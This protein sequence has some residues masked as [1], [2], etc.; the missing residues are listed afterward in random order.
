MRTIL[1]SEMSECGLACLAMVADHYGDEHDL[2]S[3]R[4]RFSTSLKGMTLTH[5]IRRASDLDLAAR[6]LKVEV[7]ELH[8]L[9]LP[10]ILHWN[11]NHFVVLKKVK[12][13]T[14]GQT[15]YVINDPAIGLLK[16]TATDLSRKFTG[17]GIEFTPT[18]KFTPKKA[19]PTISVADLAGKISGLPS[20]VAQAII[21][22][23]ALELFALVTPLFNQFVIDE[24]L[25]SGDVDMLRVSVAGFGLLVLVQIVIG[26]ARSLFLIR[27]GGEIGYQWAARLFAHLI[28][29]PASFFEKRNLG[30]VVSRFGSISSIQNTMTSLLV[31]SLLDGIMAFAALGMMFF[32]S[33]KMSLIVLSGVFVYAVSRILLF[34]LIKNATFERI[35]SAAKENTH[36]LETIRSITP[37]KLFGREETRA[38][39]WS[40]LKMNTTNRDISLQKINVFFKSFTGAI[41][42]VQLLALLYC[43]ASLVMAKEMSVGMMIAFGSYGSTFAM[44]VFSLVDL[45]VEVKLLKVHLERVADIVLEKGEDIAS[46][47]VDIETFKGEISLSCVKYRYG[48][49]E[50]L[51]IDNVSLI[52]AAG[53]SLAIVGESGSG[54][55]TLCKIL[56]GLASPDEGMVAIDNLDIQSIGL[57]QYRRMVGT[58]MQ[59]DVLLSGSIMDNIVFFDPDPDLKFAEHCAFLAAIHNEIIL[60]PMRY[61]TLVGELGSGLSG[62][63][64]QRLFIARALYK[65]PKILILDEATSHLDIDNECTINASL[66]SLNITKI[67]VAH[68]PE[69]IKA[70][71]RVVRLH[72]GKIIEDVRSAASDPVFS[73]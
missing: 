72:R 43:G 29:L 39:R 41:S 53:E 4:R 51:I 20:A 10:A 40:N 65:R 58:V 9:K 55:S 37:I 56:L 5:L 26:L 71:S 18:Q 12:R 28:R 33:A 60:M 52:I 69:T 42:S 73:M 63:Q 70:A 32:Y 47:V 44:R 21:L 25:I 30:D 15:K 64:R 22:A 36:F 31:E 66:N 54:K 46:P 35:L 3:L 57:D 1:Q 62:G 11:M 68:R 45:M 27:W 8:L 23:I 49:E 17:I 6:P 24:I 67:V 2:Q 50:P 61:Q 38:T 13:N 14:R 16:L 19:V 48:Q 59:D 34:S 7:A